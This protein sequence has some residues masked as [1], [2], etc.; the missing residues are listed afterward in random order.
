MIHREDMRE[1][2][3]ILHGELPPGIARNVDPVLRG[4]LYAARVGRAADMIIRRTSA[5]R[6]GLQ[7]GLVRGVAKGCL[8]EGGAA[9]IAK[10]DEEDR[11]FFHASRVLDAGGAAQ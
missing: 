11:G 9:D 6:L 5:V 10:T 3:E 4:F 1:A 7:P 8:G 2:V